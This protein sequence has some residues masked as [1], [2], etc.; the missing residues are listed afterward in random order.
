MYMYMYTHMYIT[1]MYMYM[2]QLVLKT[3]VSMADT[4]IC[5]LFD[6]FNV[7]HLYIHVRVLFVAIL[8]GCCCVI[9]V[10]M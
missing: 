2:H 4:C 8:M 5:C 6:I 10:Y 1:H 3:R 7:I 9:V